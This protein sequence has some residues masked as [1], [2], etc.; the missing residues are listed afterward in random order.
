MALLIGSLALA[1]CSD[2]DGSPG[3]DAGADARVDAGADAGLPAECA[4][5]ITPEGGSQ[6]T[7]GLRLH[8]PPGAVTEALAV[9]VTRPTLDA[10]PPEGLE[11]G[12][13]VF[14]LTADRADVSF[15]AYVSLHFPHEAGPIP[16]WAAR[17]FPEYGAWGAL[18][19][20]FRD[21]VWGGIRTTTLGTYTILTDVAGNDEPGSGTI[22]ASWDGRSE[23]FDLASPGNATFVPSASG[24][25]SVTLYGVS[26][27]YE[28]LK[29]DLVVTP[30]GTV[31]GALVTL[32]ASDYG[33]IHYEGI[34]P[35]SPIV[36]TLTEPEAGRLVGAVS[37]AVFRSEGQGWVETQL[38]ATFDA[39]VK[40]HF[41]GSE[42]PCTIP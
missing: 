28:S 16:V 39:H 17:H 26:A 22:A 13:A 29:L 7:C 27:A 10:T 12:S 20:C 14:T 11:Q 34:T 41:W 5:T 4:F 19:T 38:E 18:E 8:A 2:D 30:E 36:V 23:S 35:E 24:N 42:D 21:A 33:W 3:A 31:D 40:R 15:L 25:R 32:T 6:E 9:T 37:G 1:A